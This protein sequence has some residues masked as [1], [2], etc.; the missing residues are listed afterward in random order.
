VT[1]S[2]CFVRRRAL[3]VQTHTTT[4]VSILLSA[5]CFV[6]RATQGTQSANP[7]NDYCQRFVVSILFCVSCDTGHSECKPTQRLLSAFC[8]QHFVLCYVRHRALRVQTHT[9]TTV[10]ILWTLASD[11]RTSFVTSVSHLIRSPVYI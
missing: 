4:T 3:R 5:F 11:L 10:S 1:V 7:H 8:C 6:F 9:T 2:L